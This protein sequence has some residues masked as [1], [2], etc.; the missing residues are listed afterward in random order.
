MSNKE[1]KPAWWILYLLIPGMIGLLMLAGQLPL[2]SWEYQIVDVG[3]VL[4]VFGLMA[5]WIHANQ[6]ALTW[7]EVRQ[8]DWTEMRI[9]V[10][11]PES[12]DE[13]SRQPTRTELLPREN[14]LGRIGSVRRDPLDLWHP[15]S[16][17]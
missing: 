2:V 10:F 4:F 3:I 14:D 13:E 15:V 16:R 12:L 9:Q 17:N 8:T 6:S 1:Q 5:L 11:E 7:D